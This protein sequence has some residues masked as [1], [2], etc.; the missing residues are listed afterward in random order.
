MSDTNARS[1]T[2][3][4]NNYERS[5]EK[6]R[7]I[8]AKLQSSNPPIDSSLDGTTTAGSNYAAESA[9]SRRDA[10]SRSASRRRSRSP[11]YRLRSRSPGPRRS[12]GDQGH[13]SPKAGGHRSGGEELIDF[14]VPGVHVGYVI[15][16]GGTSLRR[17]ESRFQVRIDVDRQAQHA[18]GQCPIRV[19]GRTVEAV[20]QTRERILR[21]VSEAEDRAAGKADLRNPYEPGYE[22]DPNATIL[23]LSIPIQHMGPLIGRGGENIREIQENTDTTIYFA[24]PSTLDPN[25]T[26]RPGKIIGDQDKVQ[27]AKQIIDDF[28]L[29]YEEGG[30]RE[31][32]NAGGHDGRRGGRRGE[33]MQVPQSFVG[34]LVG[35]GG[36]NIHQLQDISQCRIH[37]DDRRDCP[38]EDMRDVYLDG[39]A[40]AAAHARQL[41]MDMMRNN[42]DRLPPGMNLGGGDGYYHGGHGQPGYG[43]PGS[44]TGGGYAPDQYAAYYAQYQQFAQ[45]YP[46]FNGYYGQQQGHGPPGQQYPSSYPQQQQ[47]SPH[48]Q[49]PPHGGG[50]YRR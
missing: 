28:I 45:M 34:M 33:T 9:P 10:R 17:L 18:D 19:T 4:A 21:V 3:S 35:R 40:R 22:P 23:E 46:A 14:T 41:I 44:A 48:Y 26:E 38:P 5:M 27:K 50:H 12:G 16:R 36:S 20:E 2:A 43:E 15:G 1:P 6:A 25:A 49:Q 39:P 30:P 8:A 29:S 37:L 31:S 32:R 42:S 47:Q 13:R 11:D 7:N 24:P